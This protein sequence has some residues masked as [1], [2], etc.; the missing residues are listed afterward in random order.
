MI[1]IELEGKEYSMPEGWNE[2]KVGLFEKIV[3]M[4]STYEDYKTDTEYILDMFSL[5]TGAPKEILIRMTRLSF[6][7]ITKRMSW[8]NEEVV[9]TS[10]NSWVFD[11]IE[12]MPIDNLNNLTMGDSVSLE[13]MIKE[14]NEANILGNILP[15]LIRKV[16]KVDKG[17]GK[18]KKM[19]SEFNADEYQETKD[20]F[21]D[22]LMVSDVI[23]MKSFF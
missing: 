2:V 11:G 9:A 3:H 4:A 21:N 6:E 12:Y 19:P 13:L 16:K 1:R 17:N 20:L 14:S 22:R 15:I 10:K 7:T 8:V 5:L 18:I 23:K